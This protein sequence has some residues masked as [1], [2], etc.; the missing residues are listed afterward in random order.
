[1]GL[2]DKLKKKKSNDNVDNAKII[3]D[4]FRTICRGEKIAAAEIA[5]CTSSPKEYAAKNATQFSERGISPDDTD[6]NTL[7][8]IGCVNIL[9]KNAYA[10]ELDFS[11]ELE[12]FIFNLGELTSLTSKNIMLDEDDFDSDADITDWLSELDEQL[13]GRRL[14][15]GGIDIDSDSYV[16]FLTDIQTLGKLKDNANSVGHKIDYAKNL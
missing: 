2:F 8:W 4:I 5:D 16:V 1:M 12:D 13:I 15:I 7:M 14:C 9:I 3:A 6:T 10:A 11:C